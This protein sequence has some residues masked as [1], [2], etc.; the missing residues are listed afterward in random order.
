MIRR[1]GETEPAQV[2]RTPCN[3]RL[4]LGTSW[5]LTAT[6]KG[7][8]QVIERIDPSAG[9]VPSA[10]H[11]DL[12]THSRRTL[13]VTG[14]VLLWVRPGGF[15]M[16]SPEPKRSTQHGRSDEHPQHRVFITQGKYVGL[17]E[18]TQSQFL[19]VMGRNPSFFQPG[20][21]AGLA[22]TSDHPVER[23]TFYDALEFCRRLAM[24]EGLPAGSI[25]LPT[26]AEWEYFARGGRTGLFEPG[27]AWLA[28]DSGAKTRPV[29]L[30]R[31]N[32]SGL[33]D[34][35]G[36]VLEWT[37]DFYSADYFRES[38]Q[39]DPLGPFQPVEGNFKVV[40]G[41]CF[42][43]R[44][45][46]F[47]VSARRRVTPTERLS[48]IGFRVVLDLSDRLAPVAPERARLGPAMGSIPRGRPAVGGSTVP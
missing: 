31:P 21:M 35:I 3:C 44:R 40:R 11:F 4:A 10:L 5:S 19:K 7:F 14:V 24:L 38:P 34:V 42:S 13:E 15:L 2:L 39:H 6:L 25:R 9:A 23:V 20:Q 28:D 33:H 8:P 22:D 45:G 18:V 43:D 32:P 16:G 37:N 48:T 12:N 36:N 27:E 30:R 26:E 46:S 1:A 29:G 17:T 47:R 41:G